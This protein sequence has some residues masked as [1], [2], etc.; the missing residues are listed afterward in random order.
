MAGASAPAFF[1]PLGYNR[2]MNQVSKILET[3]RQNGGY[4]R[5][6]SMSDLYL[7]TGSKLLDLYLSNGK[8][9][10]LMAGK[11]Y[12][13]V[14]DSSAGKTLFAMTMLAEAARLS[15][16]EKH[17]LIYDDAEGG[18]LFDQEKMFGTKL[19]ERIE[20][21]KVEDE[22]PQY[23]ST[24][25]EFLY[26]LDDAVEDGRPFIYVLD[27]SDAL[28]SEPEQDK[29]DEQKQAYRKGK[30]TAGSYGDGKAKAFSAGLRQ[31]MDPLR[32]TDSILIIINQTRDNLGFGFQKKT[33]SGGR[34]LT[35]YATAELWLAVNKKIK[36]N[37][38]GK[39]RSIG[40]Y[41]EVE[42]KKN[43]LTG[44]EGKVLVPVYP[45]YGIDDVGSCVDWLVAEGRWGKSGQKIVADGFDLEASQA[46][47]IE[48]I[49]SEG[50]EHKLADIVYDHWQAIMEAVS[51]K[52]KGKYE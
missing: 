20:P 41:V 5:R 3:L 2:D 35:F 18:N 38:K 7:P 48:H 33:R 46:K 10:G 1:D 15:G 36:R 28:S 45:T 49:E 8:D 47:V 23:S 16:F 14:G 11:Y 17:R 19:L 30:D 24:I 21:P 4:Q 31:L 22:E 51:L 42:V 40:N 34:A 27:S 32:Q 52:R 26:N 9:G 12:L 44:V 37:V 39:E 13:L 50:L 6:E 29:F 25:E 43:R